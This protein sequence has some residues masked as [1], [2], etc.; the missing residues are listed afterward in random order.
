M[1]RKRKFSHY[2]EFWTT[3]EQFAAFEALQAGGLLNKS[4][5]YR[6]AFQFYLNQ[7]AAMA[8][9]RPTQSN[10]QHNQ[11]QASGLPT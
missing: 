1:A 4:D 5:H 2:I 11:E 10:G 9:P 8:A 3:P 7:V 6:A